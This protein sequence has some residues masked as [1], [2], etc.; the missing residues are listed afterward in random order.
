M[1]RTLEKSAMELIPEEWLGVSDG[2]GLGGKAAV[3]C[4]EVSAEERKY[5]VWVA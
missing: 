2:R 4:T 3:F 1:E 5:S